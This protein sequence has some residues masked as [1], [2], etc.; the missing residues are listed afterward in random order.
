MVNARSQYDPRPKLDSDLSFEGD[1]GLTKQAD[2]KDADI[3]NIMKRF[4]R[5]GI[6]PDLI[7]RDGRYGDFSSVPDYQEALE[8]V[9][10]A[11]EQFNNLDANIRNRFDNDPAKFLAFASDEK[12][13]VEMEKLGL[14]NDE[15]KARL[16][17]ARDAEA[18]AARQKDAADQKAKEDA[19]IAKIKAELNK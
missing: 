10:L 15:A 6:L 13:L 18:A 9:R 3:N 4:E 7:V 17:S 14:L 5:T 8:I 1:K 19:L 12:N 2:M 16:K 11:D